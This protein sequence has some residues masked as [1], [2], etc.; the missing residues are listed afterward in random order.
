MAISHLSSIENVLA[1]MRAVAQ[2]ASS[3][4]LRV[5]EAPSSQGGFAAELQ[6]SLQRVS[7]TQNAA[8]NQAKAFELGAPGVALNDVMIDMQKAN[9]AFQ[10]TV[11]VRNRLVAAYQEIA[12]MPV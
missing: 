12:S 6:R 9:I 11:Q 1:Q 10:A 4:S 3:P 2:A 8:T 7:A 5:D